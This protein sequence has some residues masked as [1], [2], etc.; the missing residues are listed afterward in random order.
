MK[1]LIL[2]HYFPP[3]VNA[4]AKRIYDHAKI[5][6]DLGH[7]VTVITNFPNHPSGILFKG[8]KNKW[9]SQNRT[10][11]INIIRVFS[12]L[13]PNKGFIK[14]S[15]NYF[16]YMILSIV[17]GRRIKD[18]DIILATSPQLLCGL[19]GMILS[20]IKKKP[21]IFEIRD[22]WP[23]S[24]ASLGLIS[25][26]RLI[27]R[28]LKLLE[29]KIINSAKMIITVT[30]GID[31][32]VKK[33][34]PENVKLI[35]N[36][37]VVSNYPIINKS[38]KIKKVTFAYVGTIGNAHNVNII[39]RAA[40]L[41]IDEENINFTIIGDGAEQQ[42][43]FEKASNLRNVKTI[44]LLSAKEV[45]KEIRTVDVGIV[46]LLN[47]PLWKDAL[48]RKIFEFLILKKPIILSIP[49][50]QTTKM[51]KKN[52]CGI[53][54]EVDN[55]DSLVN[56][57]KYYTNKPKLREIHGANGRKLVKNNFNRKKL[58]EE[59]LGYIEK[60]VS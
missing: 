47:D 17:Q 42:K 35:T 57:I 11:N 25:K 52:S 18:T 31:S 4:P 6:S 51:I 21:Y 43:I 8:Y 60:I 36:G 37:V 34:R 50:G 16:I 1:I 5:F 2:S 40:E 39:L 13:T 15:I 19:S 48:P 54:A 56:C 49:Y 30:S 38:K 9:V 26:K 45:I 59:L 22:I 12:Y 3:E 53:I 32:Y 55:P 44:P 46:T 41:L 20:K 29:N 7:E 33:I 10:E 14:R 23:E 24:I 28:I 58:G 27:F